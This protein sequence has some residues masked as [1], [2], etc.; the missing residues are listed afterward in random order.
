[1]RR[2][3]TIAALVTVAMALALVGWLGSGG[4][5]APTS[6]RPTKQELVLQPQFAAEGG[7]RR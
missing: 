6:D 1:M 3:T 5:A 4:S 7:A 2:R